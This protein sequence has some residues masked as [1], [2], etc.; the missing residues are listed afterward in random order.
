MQLDLAG[1]IIPPRNVAACRHSPA[2]QWSHV[3]GYVVGQKEQHDQLLH[4]GTITEHY[5]PSFAI[6]LH[7]VRN[8][9]IDV[10]QGLF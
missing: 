6:I 3:T 7:L 4:E 8:Y 5:K 2:G 1:I 10:T 9:P